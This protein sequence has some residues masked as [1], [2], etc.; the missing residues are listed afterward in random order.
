MDKTVLNTLIDK[1]FD[2]TASSAEEEALRMALASPEVKGRYADEARA[3]MGVFA[4]QRRARRRSHSRFARY[5]A[6][7]A[8]IALGFTAWSIS[9]RGDVPDAVYLSYVNGTRIDQSE[10]VMAIMTAELNALGEA[11]SDVQQDFNEILSLP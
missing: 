4:A 2:G 5:A 11:E 6:A 10:S 9:S 1:Y 8:V 3:V 7:I